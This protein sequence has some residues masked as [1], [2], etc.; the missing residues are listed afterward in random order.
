MINP[1]IVKAAQQGTPMAAKPPKKQSVPIPKDKEIRD[2]DFVMPPQLA[3][4]RNRTTESIL[5]DF[6]AIM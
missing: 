5:E 4:Y 1:A 2:G 6:S 3:K